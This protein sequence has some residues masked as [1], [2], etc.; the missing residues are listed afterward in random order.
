MPGTDTQDTQPIVTDL[1]G[2]GG[3]SRPPSSGGGGGGGDKGGR[4]WKPPQRRF[5][6]AITLGMASISTFFLVP[7]AAFIVL[8]H[9]S[10]AWVPLH[11]PKILWLNTAILLVS[12][13]TLEKARRRLLAP[14]VSGF[15]NLW[16]VST[17]LG[18]AFLVGQMVAWLQLA[19]AGLYIASNQ[20]ASFFYIFTV[21]HAVHL[22][23]GIAALLFVAVR[24]FDKGNISQ[25]S[26]VNITSYYWHFMDGLWI[27]LL[28]LLYLG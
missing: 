26:A 7:C 8:A 6:T 23:G 15:R 24:D 16:R 21:A 1:G 11:L 25:V 4:H 13:Y 17:I 9:T 28:L 18:M 2:G 19:A 3:G 20:M 5:S 27:F 12:S 22:M 10:K 14:N